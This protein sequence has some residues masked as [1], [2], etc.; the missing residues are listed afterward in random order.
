[1]SPDHTGCPPEIRSAL[2]GPVVSICT[3]FTRDGDIDFDGLRT[4]LDFVIAGGARTVLLTYGDSLYTLLNE[5]E[6]ARVTRAVVEHVNGR[7]M[8]VAADGA[9][10]TRKT[11]EFATH[12]REIGADLLMVLPPDWAGSTTVESLVDHYLAVGEHMPLMIVTGYLGQRPL[13]FAVDVIA[14]LVERVSA[15]VAAKDDVTGEF[16]RRLCLLAHDRWA[17]FAGGLKQNHLNMLPYGVDGY[18][19]TFMMFQPRIAWR[20]WNAIQA[21]NMAEAR[22][23]VRDF[24]Y[25]LFDYLY[26]VEG[27]FDAAIHGIL[28]LYGIAKRYRR[29]PYHSLT[30]TQMESLASFLKGKG[31][32]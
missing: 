11:A 20:Y 28:E 22:A 26:T 32:L 27:G 30:D 3:P 25:P 23:V 10:S 16:V 2:T 14:A 18:M 21:G 5:D 9:W 8:T 19:S 24:D 15:I 7:A 31:L 12:C 29:P 4:F 13:P 1:M 6:V 17:L